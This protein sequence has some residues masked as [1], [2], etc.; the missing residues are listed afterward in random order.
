MKNSRWTNKNKFLKG[1]LCG[2]VGR[3]EKR[4]ELA[5]DESSGGRM[6]EKGFHRL[7]DSEREEDIGKHREL[8][9]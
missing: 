8:V 1:L 9:P 2:R 5:V 7:E 4:L 3:M 6:V